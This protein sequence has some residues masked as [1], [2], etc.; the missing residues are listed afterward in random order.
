VTEEQL[1]SWLDAYAAAYVS[2]DPDAAAAL[3][4]RDSTYQW[5]PFGELLRGPD[6]VR[7]KWAEWR[8]PEAK[9]RFDYEVLVVTEEIGIAR[10]IASSRHAGHSRISRYDGIFAIRLGPDSRC[11]EFREWWNTLETA[12]EDS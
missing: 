3:F 12:G 5:G 6:E 1:R 4:A 9:E 8:D 10:W 11:T 2:Q 7:R